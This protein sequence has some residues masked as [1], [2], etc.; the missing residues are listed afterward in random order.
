MNKVPESLQDIPEWAANE[1][2]HHTTRS[3]GTAREINLAKACMLLALEEEAAQ[4]LSL[5][6]YMTAEGLTTSFEDTPL[7]RQVAAHYIHGV[8][9]R[10][11]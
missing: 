11:I 6:D 7:A 4:Q 3:E 2:F 10:K 9:P 8:R 5:G 1:F